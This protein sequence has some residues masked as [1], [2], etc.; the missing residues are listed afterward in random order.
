MR[1]TSV[2]PSASKIHSSTLVA[3]PEN[4]AKL[5][6]SPVH[7]APS[8]KGKPSRSRD[9]R[10]TAVDFIAAPLSRHIEGEWLNKRSVGGRGSVRGS[11][12][13]VWLRPAL[14]QKN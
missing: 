6:P 2:L 5:T 11:H 1:S 12:W 10:T 13:C 8:G 3:L 4:S 14:P 7:V 9:R